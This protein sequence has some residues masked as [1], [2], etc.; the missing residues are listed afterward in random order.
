MSNQQFTHALRIRSFNGTSGADMSPTEL[1]RPVYRMTDHSSAVG[2][3]SGSH[4]GNV[5]N[6]WS[7][8]SALPGPRGFPAA[9]FVLDTLLVIWGYDAQTNND[10]TLVQ[11]L[12]VDRLEWGSC[13][14]L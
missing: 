14:H 12:D 9:A 6:S 5:Q 10:S 3:I 7:R 2:W 13:N 8:V 4:V 11:M 1:L